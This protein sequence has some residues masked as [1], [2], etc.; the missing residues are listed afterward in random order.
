L[1]NLYFLYLI[2]HSNI[3]L[4]FA[5]TF[6]ISILFSSFVLELESFKSFLNAVLFLYFWGR[7]RLTFP[8]WQLIA[9]TYYAEESITAEANCLRQTP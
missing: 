1:G 2:F 6:T 5:H 8:R 3:A 9:E 7:V 4:H